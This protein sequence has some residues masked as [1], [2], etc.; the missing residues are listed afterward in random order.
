MALQHMSQTKAA[1][2]G[3]DVF[4]TPDPGQQFQLIPAEAALLF[5]EVKVHSFLFGYKC[6][7]DEPES[8][9]M[10]LQ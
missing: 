1:P 9:L 5:V 7:K 3:S 2:A 4:L 6:S 8:K 10:M